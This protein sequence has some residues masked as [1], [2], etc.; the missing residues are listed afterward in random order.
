VDAA[1][2]SPGGFYQTSSAK[3]GES[4]RWRMK[5]REWYLGNNRAI[6]WYMRLKLSA[7]FIWRAAK[8]G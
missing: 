4:A 7:A 3:C 5:S 6:E 2:S 8:C 1:P